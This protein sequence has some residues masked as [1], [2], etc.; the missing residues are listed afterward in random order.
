MCRCGWFAVSMWCG[1]FY[2]VGMVYWLQCGRLKCKFSNRYGIYSAA[3]LLF[4]PGRSTFDLPLAMLQPGF[5]ATQFVVKVDL[6][7]VASVSPTGRDNGRASPVP[8]PLAS[9]A[10]TGSSPGSLMHELRCLQTLPSHHA[11]EAHWGV[12]FPSNFFVLTP[13]CRF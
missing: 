7:T 9:A 12:G 13:S 3:T 6:A 10:V 5:E 4:E 11:Q 2:F 1:A 8:S